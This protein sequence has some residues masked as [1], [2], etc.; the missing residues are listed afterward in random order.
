MDPDRTLDN[1]ISSITNTFKL[2]L[3]F[4]SNGISLHFYA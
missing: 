1:I 4:G 2:S 3:Q